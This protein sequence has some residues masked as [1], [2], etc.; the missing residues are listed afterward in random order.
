MKIKFE[1]DNSLDDM[2][3]II[4]SNKV[5]KESEDILSILENYKKDN[6]NIILG[7]RDYDIAPI[8]VNDIYYF[9]ANEKK[10]FLITNKGVYETKMRL[11]EL[12]NYNENFLRISNSEIVSVKEI[13]KLDLKYS[14]TIM[15]LMKNGDE[16]Y[17][18]RRRISKIKEYFNI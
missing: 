5:D 7:Y 2:E 15:F 6:K 11:Y 1:I 10:V 8:D 4:R 18:S 12:E 9:S 13:D 14:G 17:A 3:I 16:L